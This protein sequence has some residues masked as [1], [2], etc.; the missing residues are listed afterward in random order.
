[1]LWADNGQPAPRY[2]S[3]LIDIMFCYVPLQLCDRRLLL[4]K[5]IKVR[6]GETHPRAEHAHCA[7]RTSSA[8]AYRP[9]SGPPSPAMHVTEKITS[10]QLLWQQH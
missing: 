1:M 3:S 8:K 10:L 7:A 4:G 9:S 2:S 6:V 5:L